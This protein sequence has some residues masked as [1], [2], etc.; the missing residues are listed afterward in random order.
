MRHQG[1][2][3]VIDSFNIK[4]EQLNRLDK[5]R[6]NKTELLALIKPK[7]SIAETVLQ[8]I[9]A[10]SEKNK[11]AEEPLTT[12]KKSPY[13]A[14][15][16]S[17]VYSNRDLGKLSKEEKNNLFD[18]VIRFYR[19]WYGDEQLVA[20]R[21]EQGDEKLFITVVVIPY[22]KDRIWITPFSKEFHRKVSE[23]EMLIIIPLNKK[24]I[25]Y[26]RANLENNANSKVDGINKVKTQQRNEEEEIMNV[27]AVPVQLVMDRKTDR[28]SEDGQ[29]GKGE[30]ASEE[31]RTK[32]QLRGESEIRDENAEAEIHD[33]LNVDDIIKMF[34]EIE[35]SFNNSNPQQVSKDE[36][37]EQ[38]KFSV[39][40]R[41]K[42]VLNFVLGLPLE[43]GFGIF[44]EQDNSL[45]VDFDLQSLAQRIDI[46]LIALFR[47]L[48]E[49]E[50]V[51]KMKRLALYDFE[52][53]ADLSYFRYKIFLD[54]NDR[55][56]LLTRKEYRSN[57][58]R[59]DIWATNK[60]ERFLK[61]L[62]R[63]MKK[64]SIS[65]TE[66][67]DKKMEE[68]VGTLQE[69]MAERQEEK[70]AD[71]NSGMNVITE[72]KNSLPTEPKKE[73]TKKSGGNFF[74]RLLGR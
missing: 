34:E 28:K 2:C 40:P 67:D 5:F 21:L 3:F 1:S 23:L 52:K 29:D 36:N 59:I 10:Y 20:A 55:K 70:A 48:A 44:Y 39:T 74:L 11:Q 61:Q 33:Q 63:T 6:R 72:E 71:A 54:E 25:R 43:I 19:E 49:L 65:I 46:P 7:N 13:R 50:D 22:S 58:H 16:Y 38:T 18:Q 31:E 12:I 17:I 62:L 56:L 14:Q 4:E 35:G 15:R 8:K 73:Q 68:W 51:G 26:S 66:L 24:I 47:C 41:A 9:E 32:I 69:C 57:R 27:T 60:E 42:Q 53:N 37:Q 45:E 64:Q 30:I